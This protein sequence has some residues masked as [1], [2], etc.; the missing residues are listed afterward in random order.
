MTHPRDSTIKATSA[1]TTALTSGADLNT[2]LSTFTVSPAAIAHEHGHPKLATFLGRTFRGHK[3]VGEYFTL[4]ERQMRIKEMEFNR[5]CD[6]VVDAEKK[7][8]C[9]RGRGVWENKLTSEQWVEIFAY[10]VELAEEEWEG[11]KDKGELKVK[12]YE[13]WAD[14]GA[15]FLAE[16]GKLRNMDTD[17]WG[18]GMS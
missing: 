5:E 17:Y 14:T 6:W 4:V 12:S 10:R 11:C 3:G 13:V 9:L 16:K 18:S 1:L 15:A 8:V 7:T 2:L